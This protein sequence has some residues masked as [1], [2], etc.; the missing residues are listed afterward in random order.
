MRGTVFYDSCDSATNQCDDKNFEEW[1]FNLIALGIALAIFVACGIGA[2][3]LYNCCIR[4]TKNTDE[5]TLRQ[6]EEGHG[7]FSGV[8]LA[9]PPRVH[10][11]S[12][13]GLHGD[14]GIPLT[15]VSS[16]TPSLP[17]YNGDATK[18]PEYEE[19]ESGLPVYSQ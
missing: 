3:L 19:V 17:G 16:W 13:R 12:G 15:M 6:D 1:K 10:Q 11:S 18:A 4:R 5:E 14:G 7:E 2:M 9:V 8:V